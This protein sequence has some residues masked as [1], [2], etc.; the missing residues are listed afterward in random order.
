MDGVF[1]FM[2]D[3]EDALD[4]AIE[5]DPVLGTVL[6]FQAG[7]SVWTNPTTTNALNLNEGGVELL[8]NN[9]YGEGEDVAALPAG[10]VIGYVD[11]ALSMFGAM[12][13]EADL[14]F[15]VVLES[16]ADHLPLI[17]PLERHPRITL[18]TGHYR[19]GILLAPYT[20][21]VIA[22]QI[23][24]NDRDPLLDLTRPE[25]LFGDVTPRRG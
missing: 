18:A 16:T 15:S 5:R 13:L 19:Y 10:G 17:G 9:D 22:R 25:R 11:P 6:D 14:L 23:L 2:D 12:S 8:D 20:A 1:E 3:H 24:D 4:A 7:Q 21:D